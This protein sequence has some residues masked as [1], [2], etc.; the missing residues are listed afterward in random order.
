MKYKYKI[1]YDIQYDMWNW[2]D[3][4]KNSFMGF[5][6]IDNISNKNDLKIAKQILG[7]KKQAAEKIL[8]PYLENQKNNPK[9]K[10]NK[11]TKIIEK[12]FQEKYQDACKILEKITNRPLMSNNFTFYITTF[13]RCLYFYEKRGIF[14]YDATEDFW[15]MPIDTFLHEAH[16][17]QFIHYWYENK[18]S[19]V[20]KLKYEDFDYLKEALT[21][22]LD[23]DELKS[24]MSLPD[25]G[26]P[27]Q[28]EFRKLLYQNWQKYH[29]FDRLVDFG[30]SKLNDFIK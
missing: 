29:N 24:I 20:S 17:L 7:L 9:S 27:T 19:P 28:T 25:Q 22:V 11:F 16:H 2:R 3:S 1:I 6:W 4:I 10:L 8:K 23:D 15:G 26:Y 14:I 5:N 30:L 21:V 13:P 12:N 18:N